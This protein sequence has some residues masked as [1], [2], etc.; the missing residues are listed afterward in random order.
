MYSDEITKKGNENNNDNNK[1][2]DYE[3]ANLEH[4]L[5]KNM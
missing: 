1:T 3:A 5:P 4:V 2:G